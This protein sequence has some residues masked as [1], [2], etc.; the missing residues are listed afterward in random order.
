MISRKKLYINDKELEI[1]V[2]DEP[3]KEY[4]D[5]ALIAASSNDPLA[6]NYRKPIHHGKEFLTL[7]KVDN[8]P[9]IM[10]AT[11]KDNILPP[12]VARGFVRYFV[13][14]SFRLTHTK[15]D[16]Y[17]NR[18][19]CFYT[20]WPEYYSSRGIETIFTT[21][22]FISFKRSEKVMEKKL[23]EYGW[24]KHPVPRMYNHTPQWFFTYGDPSF[25]ESLPEYCES[26]V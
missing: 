16:G 3:F 23:N 15:Y 8:D 24:T 7:I 2:F 13:N 25:L 11:E 17:Y 14:P 18:V 12:T 5:F 21:R 10:F 4:Y 19:L 9:V 1:I 26:S 22:N 6:K 20:S